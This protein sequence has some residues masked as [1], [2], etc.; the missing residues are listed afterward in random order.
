MKTHT[1]DASQKKLGRLA[2]EIAHILMGKDT[3]EFSKNTVANVQV[4]VTNSAQ[5]DIPDFKKDVQGYK[6]YSGFPGGLRFEKLKD[7]ILKKG[8]GEV[9]RRTVYG[10]LPINKLRRRMIQNLVIK[11]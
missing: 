10:M 9:L 3:P 11:D 4:I 7:A 1:I 6:W 5:M 2:S 8:H